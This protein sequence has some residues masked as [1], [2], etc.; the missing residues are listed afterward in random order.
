MNADGKSDESIVP[1]TQAN[2]ADAESVAESV[3]ERGSAKRNTDQHDLSRT[4]SRNKR[5]SLG[6]AG[7]R[8]TARNNR[9]LKFT[10]LLHHINEDLLHAAFFDLKKNAAVGIDEV[11]WHDYELDLEDR[12][13]D[14]HG[15][16]HRGAYRAK[17]SKRIYIPKP[18]GRQRPIGIASL[19]DKLVQKAVVWVLQCIY[20]QDFLGFS[21]G[22]R[23]GKSQHKALDAL[24]V[25]LTSKKV[26]WVLDADLEG[27][28]DTIDHEW[29]IKFLEHRIGDKRILHLIRKWLRAGI[30]DEGEWSASTVGTPQGAVISPLLANVFLH[31]VLDLWIQW[32]RSAR[33]RGE[34][35]VIRYADD[36]V[37][38]FEHKYEAEACLD[39]LR[40]RLA[41]FGL[42]FNDK[43][44]CLIEFGRFASERRRNRGESRPE[45]FDF[46]GFTHRCGVTRR[47]GWFTIHRATIAKRMRATLTAIKQKLHRRRH[48]S[49]G[50]VGRWLARVMRG[51]LGYHAIPGNMVRL[52]QFRDELTK[53]WLRVLR[54]RS[55]RHRW[56]WSRMHRLVRHSL[57]PLKIL[58]PYPGDRFRARLEAGAV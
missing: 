33:G 17:P 36:F 53:L 26:N 28:F 37:I 11:T 4:P 23:P 25:A 32:W 27:F 46:L 39:E 45:T 47:N 5:R 10:A 29:L 49:I 13:T 58:H 12:I 6:L 44:T 42:K 43:K 24:S 34:I 3:E 16:I 14:L 22:Y 38:G 56:T 55:Q 1:S 2:N 50:S 15:R 48:W 57:P 52:Q 30:S 7:V 8:E 31:Y 41:K 9:E 54:R 18:D 40:A 19:E 51:W 21:Y 35:V 20:E